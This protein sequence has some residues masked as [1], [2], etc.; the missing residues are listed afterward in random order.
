[1]RHLHAV[2]IL[3]LIAAAQPWKDEPPLAATTH[4]VEIRNFAFHPARLQVAVGDTVVWINR[5]AAPHTATDSL[6]RWDS[7]GLGSGDRWTWV[8]A[9]AG[10]F[11]YLC[12]YHP[13]MQGTLEVVGTGTGA[14]GGVRRGAPAAEDDVRG[15]NAK[16]R[17]RHGW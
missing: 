13:S 14:R 3:F 11:G 7:G 15:E 1:M 4:T 16:R 9:E 5:D 12:V 8:A 10:R 2:P 17:I 6:A